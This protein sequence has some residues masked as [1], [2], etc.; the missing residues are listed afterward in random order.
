MAAAYVR[1]Y[2]RSVSRRPVLLT[3][4]S[5]ILG[6]FFLLSKNTKLI[7]CTWFTLKTLRYW[8]RVAF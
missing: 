3:V 2:D 4:C 7:Y 6:S 8:S 1:T 5:H